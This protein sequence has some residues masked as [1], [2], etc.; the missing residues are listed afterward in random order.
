[1]IAADPALKMLQSLRDEAHRFAITFHRELRHRQIE[2]SLLDDIPG[3]GSKRKIELLRK[4]GSIAALRKSTPEE[5]AE[6]VPGLGLSL[7]EK[8]HETITAA[9]KSVS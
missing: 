6:K 7:A 3:V 5:I 4:F 9:K 1:M 8:I 2:R